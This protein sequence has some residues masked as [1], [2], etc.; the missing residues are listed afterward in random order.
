MMS[1][2][3]GLAESVKDFNPGRSPGSD[4]SITFE[5]TAS[6]SDGGSS[7]GDKGRENSSPDS[8]TVLARGAVTGDSVQ[9]ASEGQTLP[10]SDARG[11]MASEYEELVASPETTS[12]Q[13]VEE[14]YKHTGT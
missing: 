9:S 11:E 1:S 13:C 2:S 14:T 7:G 8:P 10:G 12:T 5:G 4:T 6:D 3:E